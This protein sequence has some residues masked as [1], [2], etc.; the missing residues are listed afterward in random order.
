[1]TDAI[2][3]QPAGQPAQP[4]LPVTPQARRRYRQVW[5]LLCVSARSLALWL[6]AGVLA[7]AVLALVV[8]G[9]RTQASALLA[10]W[11]MVLSDNEDDLPGENHVGADLSGAGEDAD[12]SDAVLPRVAGTFLDA[13][14]ATPP[15]ALFAAGDVSARRVE[16]LRRYIANKYRVAYNATGVLV[17]TAYAVGER[18]GLDPLLILA[19]TAIESRY[20]PLAE[21]HVGAQG[22]MQV[23]TRVH[24]EKFAPFGDGAGVPLDPIANM[25]VGG[26]ILR[27]CIRRR[28]TLALGLACYVGAVGQ[29]GGYGAKV[30]AEYRRIARAA[31]VTPTLTPASTPF[32]TTP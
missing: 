1:M 2:T 25:Y 18:Y 3:G 12:A 17:N 32:V 13:F 8:P 4:F 7:L 16:A 24:R 11:Q 19:V 5:A 29:D 14:A 22:L 26:Q 10:A 20:N 6:G 27:D 15:T 21:S 30:L 28:N 9:V 31:G 23:M